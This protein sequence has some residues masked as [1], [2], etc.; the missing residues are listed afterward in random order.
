M[1]H[2]IDL[3]E[4]AIAGQNLTERARWKKQGIAVPTAGDVVRQYIGQ[5]FHYISFT[6][7]EKLGINPSTT[8]A[9]PIGIY[10]Y[11]VGDPWFERA[12]EA[13]NYQAQG[14][15][16]FAVS[17]PYIQLFR[18]KNEGR[19]VVIGQDGSILRGGAL[20]ERAMRQVE[21][22]Y[23]PDLEDIRQAISKKYEVR[24]EM[25][26]L[27]LTTM[28]IAQQQR[29]ADKDR[30]TQTL[31]YD[32]QHVARWTKMLMDLGIDG[33]E[34]RGSGTI[35]ENEPH[36]AVIFNKRF[37]EQIDTIVNPLPAAKA[38][39][40]HMLNSKKQLADLRWMLKTFTASY[41]KFI[42]RAN[43]SSEV[44]AQMLGGYL[45]EGAERFTLEEF[46]AKHGVSVGTSLPPD[47]NDVQAG[48]TNLSNSLA[49]MV[50]DHDRSMFV[51]EIL[52]NKGSS[53]TTSKV[54]SPQPVMTL[55]V[56]RLDTITVNMT[57]AAEFGRTISGWSW[58][59]TL[60]ARAIT[61]KDSKLD[62]RALPISETEK[63]VGQRMTF[64]MDGGEISVPGAYISFDFPISRDIF[65]EDGNIKDNVATYRAQIIDLAAKIIHNETMNLSFTG[66]FM[67]EVEAAQRGARGLNPT[68][69]RFV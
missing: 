2:T 18:A 57:D 19:V 5:D 14:A 34:D 37:V 9:T 12:W 22:D 32:N 36:Q 67:T 15:I 68:I 55:R 8:Y 21:R 26:R 27:W 61:L 45:G 46:V 56:G 40:T 16:P 53:L 62:M 35:H 24:S 59:T 64:A 65:D 13:T 42:A 49:R 50:I 28:L 38:N 69:V 51:R 30:N 6:S 10:A 48:L 11:P 44:D 41:D 43:L 58:R 1:K 23:E 66:L 31:K 52:F 3:V 29:Y 17:Q 54:N 60:G 20:V 25:S 39:R 7:I 47:L 33:V 4:Q 63:L